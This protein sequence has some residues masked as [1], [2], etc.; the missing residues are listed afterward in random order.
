MTT[1][2]A[3]V[4]V[5][6]GTADMAVAAADS[7]LNRTADGLTV[8]V[9]L[10]DNASPGNDAEVLRQAASRWG[11]A[12]TLHLE[13][14]NHG[15]GRGNNVVLRQLAQRAT[16]PAKVFLLNPDARLETNAVAQLSAFLDT[17]PKAAVV[18]SAILHE[19]SLE[20]ATCA[21]RFPSAVSEFVGAV[22][23]GPLARLF[24]HTEVA[25]SADLPMQQVDWVSGASMMARL[26][27]LTGVNFFDPDYF[28]YYEE[29]DLMNRLK[30]LGWEVWH[31]P[32]AKIVHIAGAATGVT[33]ISDERP[34]LPAYWYESWRLYFEKQHG[35]S[36]AR[37]AAFARLSGTI[38][39][40]LIGRLRSKPSNNP[41]NFVSDFQR[42]VVGPLFRRGSG[43]AQR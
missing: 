20:P 24:R 8:E 27:A 12:V 26:D 21:F 1:D 10:V 22:N 6:Y 28:L 43:A 32:Q 25:F 35:R 15:F 17:H 39:G 4:I 13:P 29:V 34:P 2:V 3:V 9:H 40:D 33:R 16:P 37:V 42:H 31:L 41:R 38:L 36:G 14:T 19:G 5:N 23:F 11:D 7:I 30:R 18:G